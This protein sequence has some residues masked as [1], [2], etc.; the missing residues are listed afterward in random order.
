MK[1][2]IA[3]KRW[4][5]PLGGAEYGYPGKRLR[6]DVTGE[7]GKLGDQIP[8]Y[9]ITC[10][11]KILDGRYRD[12]YVMSGCI[13]DTILKYFPELAPLV[14]VHLSGVDGVPMHAESNARHWAGLSK[15]TDGSPMVP[16]TDYGRHKL[17]RA[18]DGL[19]WTPTLLANHLRVT[20][21]DAREIRDAMARGIPWQRIV[22][23]MKLAD[24]WA[25]DA[26]A[27]RALL[28]DVAVAI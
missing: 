5:R 16:R 21:D 19:E 26:A 1:S 25:A 2:L 22:E 6:L 18:G 4:T 8:Y 24:R 7:L 15:W 13:H 14:R 10:D 17:E 23:T 12:P 27:A 20:V 9:S 11:V 3:V 28:N